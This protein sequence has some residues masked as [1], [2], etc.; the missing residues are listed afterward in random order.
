MR[1]GAAGRWSGPN[2]LTPT[3]SPE[4]RG[5]KT[6]ASL[7]EGE[8]EQDPSASANLKTARMTAMKPHLSIW[9]IINMNVGFFGIQFSFGLP[10]TAGTKPVRA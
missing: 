8:R 6:G 4:G 3:L 5:S 1:A 10:R 2:T 9:Q 7:P